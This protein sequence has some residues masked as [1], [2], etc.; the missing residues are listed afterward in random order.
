M[1]VLFGLAFAL[2]IALMIAKNK[3]KNVASNVRTLSEKANKTVMEVK[4]YRQSAPMVSTATSQAPTPPTP[5]KTESQPVALSVDLFTDKQPSFNA[6]S[7]PYGRLIKCMLVNA[8]ESSNLKTPIIG[9]VTE[10]LYSNGNLIIPAGAEV[11]GVSEIDN[12]R[13][14]ISD[15]GKWIFV[16]TDGTR[17]EMPVSGTALN[18]APIPTGGWDISDGSAGLKG[19]IV[20]S[21]NY[22][23]LKLFLA[24]GLSG[25]GEGF[26]DVDTQ[27]TDNGIVS[28]TT[29]S[30]QNALATAGQRSMDQVARNIL[31]QIQKQGF[32]VRVP[33]AT[34]FYVYVTQDINPSQAVPGASDQG[35]TSQ[36]Q[37]NPATKR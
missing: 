17:R 26:R 31:A 24:T 21:D 9:L 15:G 37:V 34:Q 12:V 27:I 5:T 30:L 22:A 20:K 35:G 23:E 25:I 3:T 18:H 4:E 32:Y 14:R 11:H 36:I 7:A 6:V 10:S 19:Y 29:G 13:E 2:V 16:W 33:A 8:L 28:Q 1:L